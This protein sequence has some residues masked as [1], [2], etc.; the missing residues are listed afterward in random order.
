MEL[1]P[2]LKTAIA[3]MLNSQRYFVLVVRETDC[4]CDKI[5][6]V[7]RIWEINEKIARLLRIS[8][9]LTESEILQQ[10]SEVEQLEKMFGN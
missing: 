8:G 10:A 9:L 2:D 6:A 3:L 4:L 1:E 7:S 5:D